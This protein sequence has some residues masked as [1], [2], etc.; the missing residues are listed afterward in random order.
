M[1]SVKEMGIEL[2]SVAKNRAL[3]YGTEAGCENCRTL[4]GAGIR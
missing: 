4:E 3:E 2:V 1:Y